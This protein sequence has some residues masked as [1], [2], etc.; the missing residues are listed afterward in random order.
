MD[1]F[2]FNLYEKL[3]E[4]FTGSRR[5]QPV[6]IALIFVFI[7]LNL[8]SYRQEIIVDSETLY[9]VFSSLVQALLALVALMGV[10][11]VF[12]LQN[13]HSHE[14]RV[15]DETNDPG[16]GYFTLLNNRYSTI[17]ALK[18]AIESYLSS[19]QIGETHLIST[20]NKR[21]DDLLLS[22]RLVA[23][24]AIKYTVYT[25]AVALLSLLF[26]I[27]TKQISELYLGLNALYLSF[28]LSSYSLFLA[29][30]G[31]AYSIRD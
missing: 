1:N 21:I 11:S 9:W 13:L 22:K 26:L 31:V 18:A 4:Y 5:K 27:L 24:Y 6:F 7:A 19:H 3:G 15:L 14:Q 2:T 25:F 30:K 10:V 23:N 17:H 16:R 8:L 28:I 29:T 12:K 20:M